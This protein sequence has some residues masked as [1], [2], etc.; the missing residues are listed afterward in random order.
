MSRQIFNGRPIPSIRVNDVP[1]FP[2]LPGVAAFDV[3]SLPSISSTASYSTMG[4]VVSRYVPLPLYP[5]TLPA[6]EPLE[7]LSDA[8]FGEEMMADHLA[9][10]AESIAL[11]TDKPLIGDLLL[12]VIDEE[13]Q[14]D[15]QHQE[16]Q[17]D[18]FS[19]FTQTT[20]AG[21][22]EIQ[23]AQ[24]RRNNGYT[25]EIRSPVRESQNTSTKNH[26]GSNPHPHRA[27]RIMNPDNMHSSPCVPE[28]TS[29]DSLATSVA[30]SHHST[31]SFAPSIQQRESIEA[32]WLARMRARQNMD[33]RSFVARREFRIRQIR[34][35]ARE[36]GRTPV[37]RNGYSSGTRR[38]LGLLDGEG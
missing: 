24:P 5:P 15:G 32:V 17:E 31:F 21:H 35:G 3:E 33:E 20:P 6:F 2:L 1:V 9:E 14:K 37:R 12:E 34:M 18:Q 4:S 26:Y 25:S 29:L 7:P 11:P 13:P 22:R 10:Q 27:L 38:S 28:T 16:E 19:G 8:M 23:K 30:E 36:A